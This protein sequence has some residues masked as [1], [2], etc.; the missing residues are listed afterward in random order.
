MATAS[1]ST[2]ASRVSLVAYLDPWWP[3]TKRST[4]GRSSRATR[5][6]LGFQGHVPGEEGLPAV[7]LAEDGQALLVAVPA[8]GDR[9]VEG[10][11]RLPQGQVCVLCDIVHGDVQ[12]GGPGGNGLPQ[13]AVRVHVGGDDGPHLHPLQQLQH[14]AG[15]VVVVVG[16]D[17][18]VQPVAAQ[19]L[20]VGGCGVP[21][22]LVPPQSIMARAEPEVTTT[23]CPW[24]TSSRRKVRSWRWAW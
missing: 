16:E 20:D 4:W 13:V 1:G 10:D 6:S 8:A 11:L 5:S 17:Q 23:H 12:L 19:G 14:P 22:S 7:G 3:A 15:V 24:P 21:G 2:A 18:Q 9:G